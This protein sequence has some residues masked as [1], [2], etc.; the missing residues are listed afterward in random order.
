MVDDGLMDRFKINEVYGMHNYPGMAVGEFSI[1]PGPIMAAADYIQIDIEGKGAHA[2]RPHFGTDSVLVGA[3]I[4]NNLQSIVSRNVDPLESAVVSICMFHAGSTDNVI[5][6]TA[7]LRGTARSLTPQVQDLL[8]KRVPEIAKGTAELYGAKAT[9]KYRRGY[10]VLKNH[11][12]QTDFAA[13]VA[14]EIAGKDK[15]DIDMAPVMGAE[16]F[17]FM[18]NA[19]PGAFI[20]VGNGDSAGLH[21][22][23][24][25]FN[26]DVIPIGTSYWVKLVET[27]LPG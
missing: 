25:N 23:A 5:P 26:D 10:P 4:I 20:F 15:V 7:Q 1:R 21:H 9:V 14:G 6:Q 24:Y 18:L 16:D 17:S 8:E 22:P 11:A 19:R 2:A 3:Q 12:A 27:A 13:A